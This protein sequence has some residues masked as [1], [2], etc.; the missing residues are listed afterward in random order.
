MQKIH[1][2]EICY[3]DDIVIIAKNGKALQKI[4]NRIIKYK[5]RGLIILDNE[6]IEWI[7]KGGKLF[8]NIL[9]INS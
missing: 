4:W 9:K 6:I 8:N 1:I 5:Y 2:T 3:T 7:S